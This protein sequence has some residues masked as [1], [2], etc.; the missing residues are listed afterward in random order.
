MKRFSFGIKRSQNQYSNINPENPDTRPLALARIVTPKINFS[1]TNIMKSNL[2]FTPKPNYQSVKAKMEQNIEVYPDPNYSQP[3]TPRGL[4]PSSKRM[5]NF[6]TAANNIDSGETKCS[7]PRT[8]PHNGGIS[9]LDF[10]NKKESKETNTIMANAFVRNFIMEKTQD[11]QALVIQN[12]FRLYQKK[13]HWKRCIHIHVQYHM[14]L[15]RLAF[16]C[17]QLTVANDPAKL[18][19][20]FQKFVE[21]YPIIKNRFKVRDMVP[22]R[23]FY[24]NGRLFLPE[25]YTAN[26]VYSFIY[27][28]SM[29]LLHRII[30]LWAFTTRK[31][32]SHRKRLIFIRLTSKKLTMF[33]QSFHIFQIWHRYVQWNKLERNATKKDK[34]IKVDYTE[35]NLRWNLLERRLN[36]KRIHIL[37]ATA[38]SQKR[39]CAKA[40]RALY[41]RSI[42]AIAESQVTEQS[43]NF[44]DRH[45]YMLAHR[46]WLTFMQKRT[47]ERQSLRDAFQAWYTCV[48]DHAERTFMFDMATLQHDNMKLI[49]IMNS[50]H[51]LAQLRK[52]TI[53]SMMLKTQANPSLSLGI[54][55]LLRNEYELFFSTWT[56]RLWIRFIRSRNRW[57]NFASWSDN[58]NRDTETKQIILSELRRCATL[59]LMRRIYVS[60]GRFFPRHS[61]F[62]FELTSREFMNG[63]IKDEH[64]AKNQSWRFMTET[65]KKEEKK[66]TFTWETLVRCFLLRLNMLKK[67]DNDKGEIS[68]DFSVQVKKPEENPYFEKLRTEEELQQAVTK[69]Q[70]LMR[71]RLM[72]KMSRDKAVLAGMVSHISAAKVA[73]SIEGFS[74]MNTFTFVK[75]HVH[76]LTNMEDRVIVFGDLNES[77]KFLIKQIHEAKPKIPYDF[78][79]TRNKHVDAF[80]QRLRDPQEMYKKTD[81]IAAIGHITHILKNQEQPD[82]SPSKNP[83]IASSFGASTASF[84]EETE[85]L[86]KDDFNMSLNLNNIGELPTIAEEG[87]DASSLHLLSGRSLSSL[88][89]QSFSRS[90]TLKNL[91]D[92]EVQD[93]QTIFTVENLRAILQMFQNSD[94]MIASVCR[95]IM[96]T[97]GVFIDAGAETISLQTP[98]AIVPEADQSQRNVM[99]RNISFFFAQLAGYTDPKKFPRKVI[100][101]PFVN[102]AVTAILTLHCAITKTQLRQYCDPVPFSYQISFGDELYTNS[103]ARLWRDAKKKYPKIECPIGLGAS[104]R[105][106][107]PIT[108]KQNRLSSLAAFSSVSSSSAALADDPINSRDVFISCYLLAYV[109]SFDLLTDFSKDEIIGKMSK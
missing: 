96:D 54:I 41:N 9:V 27:L 71:N 90:S 30:R 47:Q 32:R 42:E 70:Q 18:E 39:V 23:L 84:F 58:P 93:E 10:E 52:M 31:R 11:V 12:A 109:F 28:M 91:L 57:K 51:K 1:S 46:A 59:K 100:S 17:W 21:F 13:V 68:Y 67:F 64:R 20:L 7:D 62:S 66:P 80:H 98:D 3:R 108:T 97:S 22:F 60:T 69:N 101:P 6:L 79:E 53:M 44:R 56:F 49:K 25:G 48:Y 33:G 83:L 61:G 106:I 103:I 50:W 94:A 37:R 45:L 35:V 16:L 40:V 43:D 63:R 88:Q 24:I 92:F 19:K 8:S 75:S 5:T 38:H 74:T 89:G 4:S 14:R 99:T 29:P 34:F 104:I 82:R 55:F 2:F 72:V 65:E 78:E 107:V 85:E 36:T 26:V 15:K 105:N 102:E 87:F 95:F 77:I 76:N 81:K 73:E 86:V